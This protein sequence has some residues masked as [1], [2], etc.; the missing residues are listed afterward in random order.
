MAYGDNTD[1]AA[2]A[3]SLFLTGA[4]GLATIMGMYLAFNPEYAKKIIAD[5]AAVDIEEPVEPPPPPPPPP[6]P[7]EEVSPP[8]DAVKSPFTPPPQSFT[9]PPTK[10]DAPVQQTPIVLPKQD[11]APPP[12]PP[13]PP[14]PEK[15]MSKKAVP[16]GSP[17]RWATTDDYPSRDLRE[18]NEG[19]ARF[20][21]QIG[22]NGRVTACSITGSSGH[23]GLDAATCKFVTSRAKFT[24]A[25]DKSGNPTTG[26]FSSSVRWVIPKE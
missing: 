16:Q 4:L 19:V 7:Q 18:E 10:V 17:S 11:Q 13:P 23:P 14:P 3:T 12:P 2:A 21:V 25:L 1:K 20:S 26:T 5:V 22:T 6:E 15:D 9:P 8:I 24:P